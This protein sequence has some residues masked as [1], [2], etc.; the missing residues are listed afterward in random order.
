M[1]AMHEI[2]LGFRD[3]IIPFSS[4]DM[5]PILVKANA[6]YDSLTEVE[7]QRLVIV[8]GQFFRACEEAFI[9]HQERR[10]DERNWKAIVEYYTK[11]LGAP[12]IRRG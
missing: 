1:S 9:Q 11:I 6:D 10:L 12:A 7:A 3:A 2:S 5:A 8:M 4:E